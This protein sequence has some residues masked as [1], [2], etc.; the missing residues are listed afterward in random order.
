MLINLVFVFLLKTKI[1]L[2]QMHNI[3]FTS[4]HKVN[5]SDNFAQLLNWII[6]HLQELASHMAPVIF[7]AAPLPIQHPA[8]ELGS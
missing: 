8:Y 2:I 6:L 1:Q 7:P 4:I 3:T 5:S